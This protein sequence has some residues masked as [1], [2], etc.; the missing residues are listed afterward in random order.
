VVVAIM[1]ALAG[2]GGVLAWTYGRDADLEERVARVQVHR[3]A[4]LAAAAKAFFVYPPPDEPTHPTAYTEVLAIE[5]LEAE[6]G[7][8][9]TEAAQELRSEF[10]ETLVRGSAIATGTSPAAGRSRSTTTSR[11]A[12]STPTTSERARGHR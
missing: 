9:A 11:R 8:P 6:L 7:A 12:C 5:D 10:A 2:L 4:A 3:D 1:L